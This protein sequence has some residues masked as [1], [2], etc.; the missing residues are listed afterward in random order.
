MNLVTKL[1]GLDVKS[2]DESSGIIEGYASSFGNIDSYGDTISPGAFTATLSKHAAEGTVI[3]LLF[4][5]DRSL[6]AHIGQIIDATEDN[7]GLLIRAQLDVEDEAGAKALRLAQVRRIN[8][9]SIGFVPVDITTDV[10]D[11]QPVTVINEVD[12]REVSLVLNPA[13]AQAQITSVKSAVSDEMLHRQQR[14]DELTGLLDRIKAANAAEVHDLIATVRTKS[15]DEDPDTPRVDEVYLTSL[16]TLRGKDA[17]DPRARGFQL[18]D[19]SRAMTE[20]AAAERI[21][22]KARDERRELTD[23]ERELLSRPSFLA[24]E[25]D[26]ITESSKAMD[27]LRGLNLDGSP[28]DAEGNIYTESPYYNGHR[29]QKGADTMRTN[30]L[31]L[32]AKHRAEVATKAVDQISEKAIDTGSGSLVV[33]TEVGGIT[34]LT[35]PATSILD[36]LPATLQATPSFSYLKQTTRELNADR[37]ATGAEKPK[38]QLGFERVDATLEVVAHVVRN[39]DEYILKDVSGLESFIGQEMVAG[40]I[41]AV[42]HWVVNEIAAAEGRHVQDYDQDGFT[43]ARMGINTLQASGL[44]PA[45]IVMAPADWARMETAK[46][47]GSGAF[48]FNAAPVDQTNGTLWGVPVSTSHRLAEGRGYVIAEGAAEVFHDG[49]ARLAFNASQDEFEHNQL[50]FRAEGRFRPVVKREAGIV[51]LTLTD[52]PVDEPDAQDDAA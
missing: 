15:A 44:T 1:A 51:E 42:E 46:A 35:R 17:V 14:A 34:E 12:L 2:V 11:D 43:T 39:V 36:L 28:V 38:S 49:Q 31:P 24:K 3:P 48:L 26:R 25:R 5:H 18:D 52:T 23:T 19:E 22:T 8:G 13:D 32:T 29:G 6:N 16:T 40:V 4:E 47:T 21:I 20:K 10:L 50:S 45:A 37:V 7:D 33:S 30:H 41:E 9:M 27:K